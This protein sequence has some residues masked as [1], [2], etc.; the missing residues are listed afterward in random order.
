MVD[1]TR[2]IFTSTKSASLPT[3]WLPHD[4]FVW[5]P[6]TLIGDAAK[7]GERYMT[8]VGE[9]ILRDGKQGELL[10][11]PLALEGVD[12]ICQLNT[13]SDAA[14]LHSLRT[15][16][17]RD[18]IYTFISCILV[19]VNPFKTINMYSSDFVAK[20][21]ATEDVM[22]LPP[23]IYGITALAFKQ[24][25]ERQVSQAM[26]VSGE[27][28]AGKTENTKFVLLFISEVLRSRAGLADR[29]LEVNPLLEAF[30]NAKTVRN[31]NSSRFGKWIEVSI[32]PATRSLAGASVTDYLLEETRVCAQGKG[33]RNYHIFY[34]LAADTSGELDALQV[35]DARRFKYLNGNPV[36]AAGV[37]DE[38][39][40]MELRKAFDSMAVGKETQL[41]IFGVAAG[42][43]HLGNVEFSDAGDAAAVSEPAALQ[44]AAKTLGLDAAVLS[45]CLLFK[46]ITV[47]KDVTESP[48]DKKKA[49]QARDSMSKL[50]YGRLFRWLV[51]K[52]NEALLGEAVAAPASTSSACKAFVSVL[53]SECSVCS[54]PV[55]ELATV[56]SSCVLFRRHRTVGVLDIAGF[57]N[58][59]TNMLEQLFINLSNEKLQQVFNET[60]FKG[61]LA[62]Y[63][64]EG[65]E[66][67]SINYTDNSDILLL[68]EGKGGLLPMLDDSTAGI[69]QTDVL[70]VQ[71][72]TKAHEKNPSFVKPKFPNTPQFGVK[73]YAGIV[74]Y[75]A[76]G[77]LEKNASAQPPEVLE[78]MASSSLSVLQQ[79]AKEPQDEA[80][81]PSPG[82]AAKK[83]TVGQ[84][85]RKSLQQLVDKLKSSRTHFIRCMKPNSKLLPGEFDGKMVTDQLRYSGILD[86]VKIRKA[87]YG[88]RQAYIDF[89]KR[90]VVLLSKQQKASL[91][92][93]AGSSSS[94]SVSKETDTKKATTA[95]FDLLPSILGRKLSTTDFAF[96]ATKVFLKDSLA[97][98]LEEHRRKACLGPVV[99]IQAWFRGLQARAAVSEAKSLNEELKACIREATSQCAGKALAAPEPG[100]K[101]NTRATMMGSS[102]TRLDVVLQRAVDVS[103]RLPYMDEALKVRARLAAVAALT[104]QL[105]DLATSK[106]VPAIEAALARAASHELQSELTESLRSRCETLQ[107]QQMQRRALQMCISS[108]SLAEVEH[109]VKDADAQKLAEPSSWLLADGH[110]SYRRAAERLQVLV[111]ERRRAEEEERQRAEEEARKRAE[112]EARR[113]AEEEAR[114][115]AEEEARK[116]AQAEAQ[117]RAAEEAQKLAEEESRKHAE[118]EAEKRA[119]EEARRRV[120]E[121][122]RALEEL[123]KRNEEERQRQAEEA[124]ANAKKPVLDPEAEAL[125]SD[126]E[127]AMADFD[128]TALE[129]AFRKAADLGLPSSTFPEA[130]KL[131]LN[132]QDE[133][134]IRAKLEELGTVSCGADGEDEDEFSMVNLMGMSNLSDQLEAIGLK[135]KPVCQDMQN[136]A[137]ALMRT[138]SRSRKSIFQT[139][140]AAELKVAERVFQSLENF[141][142]L[143]DPLYWGKGTKR[144]SMYV[145]AG[146]RLS[147]ASLVGGA[148]PTDNVP[149]MLTF[150][151]EL[152]EP[153]TKLGAAQEM[154]AKRSFT[155]L[156][157]CMG[158]KP[159][160][161]IGDKEQPIL[162]TARLSE[163]M[164]DEVFVQVMK[165][166][167]NNPSTESLRRGWHLLQKLCSEVYPSAELS[168]FLRAFLQR[169][170]AG[171]DRFAMSPA[172]RQH[173]RRTAPPCAVGGRRD[174]GASGRRGSFV[175]ELPQLAGDILDLLGPGDSGDA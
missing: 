117:Q 147:L 116:R 138:K 95:L 17:A 145:A 12:D 162:D 97:G 73:H 133:A 18:D 121:E 87:G 161:Y 141:S 150:G 4:E 21:W 166:L 89:V 16:Y 78:M 135:A 93:A 102:L 132:L 106:D 174:S 164:C 151:T 9:I 158:D 81:G 69:R 107:S 76:D 143:R 155:N 167:T 38:S 124:A 114:I 55:S 90:Y 31:N 137:G 40:F 169:E 56:R 67:K 94:R 105:Q 58:F 134:F 146:P 26:L 115:R 171:G 37:N 172:T 10:S 152:K 92:T 48:L 148:T 139:D 100:H 51:A 14:I 77:F 49:Y 74:T 99:T 1:R 62:E 125:R 88:V 154:A 118:A 7:N 33:E 120:E 103:V 2:S 68:L 5:L 79:L 82:K 42:L 60:I 19:A 127:E 47:G 168:E 109:A 101:T 83:A 86:A 36:D 144:R 129:V 119:A 27:S 72:L 156:L 157:R 175:N 61:E 131:F 11:D 53:G 149:A 104:R 39:N 136:V 112:E 108:S 20:Y 23:H 59:A 122:K 54:V 163:E 91:L 50:V 110:E 34:Q 22:G 32:D 170:A 153:L 63:S 8:D 44:D 57:E 13:V 6:G 130:H 30:G 75:T 126:M 80:A 96:G 28:G 41:A 165:Q 45:K 159:S 43:L 29:L 65:V 140:D 46:R 128:A 25:M 84:A 3:H 71:Q 70:Y 160:A 173:M 98:L 52:C 123:Q 113:R 64:A 66:T 111:E 15:R 142:R 35:S 85:F 24:L